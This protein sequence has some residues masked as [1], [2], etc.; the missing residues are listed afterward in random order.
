[1]TLRGREF[2]VPAR[3]TRLEPRI[4]TKAQ[5]SASINTKLRLFSLP[6]RFFTIFVLCKFNL[7][8]VSSET[9]SAG[10][11]FI[12]SGKLRFV[13]RVMKMFGRVNELPM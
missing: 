12:L 2:W 4:E 7:S 13:A 6:I 5:V 8:R 1:M 3:E 10:L 11:N 9:V